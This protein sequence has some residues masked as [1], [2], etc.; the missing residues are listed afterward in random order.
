MAARMDAALTC[1]GRLREVTGVEIDDEGRE[2]P[3]YATRWTGRCLIY[4]A[5]RDATVVDVGGATTPLA[6]YTVL[7]PAE[8]DVRIGHVLDVT[9]SP[10]NPRLVGAVFRIADAPL[11]AW[12]AVRH[13]MAERI[14]GG[15]WS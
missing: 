9:V 2:V 6:R 8:V 13:V 12:A 4:P 3:A 11:D 14:E 10:D 5:D 7:L 15:I 1:T